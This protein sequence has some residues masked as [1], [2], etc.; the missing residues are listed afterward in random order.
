MHLDILNK[1][2]ATVR[3]TGPLREGWPWVQLDDLCRIERGG[4][5]SDRE[6]INLLDAVLALP[7]ATI[8]KSELRSYRLRAE[9]D[10]L[11]P[12][13]RKYAIA[14]CNRL[15]RPKAASE[16]RSD[17]RSEITP[18]I[19]VPNGQPTLSTTQTAGIA[20]AGIGFVFGV[21]V[22]VVTFVAAWVYCVM[23]Y[24]FVLGLGLGWFPAAICA[25]IV[26]WAT[27]FLWGPALLIILVIGGGVL[28]SA[29]PGLHSGFLPH[30]LLGAG[31][32]WLVWRISPAWLKGK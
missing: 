9:A 3:S 23:T 25:G 27:V 11:E 1:T 12:D 16:T 22:G 32:G 19:K 26:G 15:M 4:Q 21:G 7:V 5:M 2:I 6:L 24:G 17:Q 10:Q 20:Y 18:E 13:D 31:I 29:A 30:I 14:L 28:I 8:T